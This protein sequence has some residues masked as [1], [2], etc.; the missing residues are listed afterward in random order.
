M[1]IFE[2]MFKGNGKTILPETPKG[3]YCYFALNHFLWEKD[4]LVKI[5]DSYIVSDIDLRR[6]DWSPYTGEINYR[7]KWYECPSNWT[8]YI[9][10]DKNGLCIECGRNAMI[11]YKHIC[12]MAISEE[13]V[14]KV[15]G[16]I[17]CETSPGQLKFDAIRK[18]LEETIEKCI[19]EQNLV[20]AKLSVEI[21]G[22]FLELAPIWPA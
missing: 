7:W 22:T 20:G 21:L 17:Q 15:C 18:S 2:A 5:R 4:S 8:D 19:C 3:N 12:D 9:K 10:V 11:H 13:E 6:N 14:E 16:K 1:N